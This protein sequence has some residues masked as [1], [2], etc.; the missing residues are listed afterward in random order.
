MD[1]NK[2]KEI[3][4]NLN[5]GIKYFK[6]DFIQGSVYNL[7]QENFIT[8]KEG[9]NLLDDIFK[10]GQTY[11]YKTFLKKQKGGNTK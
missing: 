11:S 2:L 8:E 4:K 7:V 1:N 10:H 9:Y 5:Y 3:V 6:L